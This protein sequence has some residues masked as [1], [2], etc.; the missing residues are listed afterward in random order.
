MIYFLMPDPPNDAI[1]YTHDNNDLDDAFDM[2]EREHWN[3]EMTSAIGVW[4][5]GSLVA[6]VLPVYSQYIKRYRA[7]LYKIPPPT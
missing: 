1:L 3:D 6:Q 5:Q 2:F 4:R 7:E